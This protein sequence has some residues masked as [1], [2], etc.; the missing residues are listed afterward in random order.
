MPIKCS[1]IDPTLSR[2]FEDFAPRLWDITGD[3]RPELLTGKRFR[4]H[5][6]K[7]PGADDPVGLYYFTWDQARRQFT[8]HNIAHGPVG[9]G[10]GTG[11]YFA[12]ADLRK[13]G[14]ND[15]VVAGKD[16]LAVFFNEGM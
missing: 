2:V 16:G 13:I 12:V 11:I 4:A 6:D 7:D 8:K 3:G 14:R 1:R 15:I 5:N 10:K 9:V